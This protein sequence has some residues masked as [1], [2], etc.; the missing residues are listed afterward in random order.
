MDKNSV[1]KIFE[2]KIGISFQWQKNAVLTQVIFRDVGFHLSVDEIVLFLDQIELS[3]LNRPCIECKL[4]KNCRSMLLK[5]P[6]NKV[7]MAVSF[8]ELIEIEDLLKGT[9]FQIELNTFLHN[10]CKN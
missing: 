1:Y 2:N 3:R 6:A 7:S 8:N 9:L 5:T 4:G 10:I